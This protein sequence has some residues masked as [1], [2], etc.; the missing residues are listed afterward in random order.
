MRLRR[1]YRECGFILLVLACVA[2][3][4]KLLSFQ[5]FRTE[6]ETNIN[7][8]LIEYNSKQDKDDI[9]GLAEGYPTTRRDINT[10]ELEENEEETHCKNKALSAL[11]SWPVLPSSIPL[12]EGTVLLSRKRLD[13]GSEKDIKRLEHPVLIFDYDPV[14]GAKG[15]AMNPLSSIPDSVATKLSRAWT[16]MKNNDSDDIDDV[17]NLFSKTKTDILVGKTFGG[18]PPHWILLLPVYE[19][20]K[21]ERKDL[22][23]FV[24]EQGIE[25]KR[26][27]NTSFTVFL[28]TE[29]EL[30]LMLLEIYGHEAKEKSTHRSFLAYRYLVWGH[31]QL[32]EEISYGVSYPCENIGDAFTYAFNS[33]AANDNH[34]Q[35][36]EQALVDLESDSLI[37]QHLSYCRKCITDFE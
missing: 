28:S 26:I 13:K 11:L 18:Y 10:E 35:G 31:G 34:L 27:K 29:P 15:V 17:M 20:A 2:V 24:K 3:L 5:V 9:E 14:V 8:D 19:Q 33:D 32:E 37:V 4:Q 1:R 16:A 12:I 21:L 36:L 23:R 22:F 30:F 7:V 6:H 25:Y